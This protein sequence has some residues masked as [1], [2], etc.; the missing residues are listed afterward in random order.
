MPLFGFAASQQ[1]NRKHIY[2]SFS[3]HDQIHTA[4]PQSTT[5]LVQDVHGKGLFPQ[6]W[7]SHQ[8]ST[9]Q[10]EDLHRSQTWI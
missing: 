1:P 2:R 5:W 8:E 9:E 4:A 10:K 7:A 6:L 3:C